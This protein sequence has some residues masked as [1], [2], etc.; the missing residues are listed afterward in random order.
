MSHKRGSLPGEKPFSAI[1]EAVDS[2]AEQPCEADFRLRSASLG[3]VRGHSQ[4]R[5]DFFRLGRF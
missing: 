3:H 2:E 5:I 1:F 4:T